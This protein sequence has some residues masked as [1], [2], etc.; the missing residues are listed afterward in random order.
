MGLKI[1][2]DI[3][4]KS[5]LIEKTN[6][7]KIEDFINK[8]PL[9]EKVDEKISETKIDVKTSRRHEVKTSEKRFTIR[10]EED[11][12]KRWKSLEYKKTSE[13]I[14]I[15]LQQFVVEKLEKFLKKEG[16]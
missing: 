14:K 1:Q 13:N 15:S 16:F 3:E 2:A 7:S 6:Q 8:A 5:K 11:L 10:I 12:Y 4:K 9:T